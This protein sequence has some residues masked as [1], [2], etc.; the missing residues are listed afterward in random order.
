MSCHPIYEIYL[1][2]SILKTNIF[3]S[4]LSNLK[5]SVR[6]LLNTYTRQGNLGMLQNFSTHSEAGLGSPKH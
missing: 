2:L 4:K 5:K 3:N 1:M 6:I